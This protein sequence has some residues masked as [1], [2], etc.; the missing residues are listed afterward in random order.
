MVRMSK[1]WTR[2]SFVEQPFL[3]LS[4]SSWVVEI[5]VACVQF[6]TGLDAS[7]ADVADHC[8]AGDGDGVEQ[9]TSRGQRLR[10]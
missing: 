6:T 7:S 8:V 3:A 5:I 1:K 4:V 2:F 10:L 9:Q